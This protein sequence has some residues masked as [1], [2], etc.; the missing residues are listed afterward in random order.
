VRDWK[1]G[2]VTLRTTNDA[3]GRAVCIVTGMG[4][5][6][7]LALVKLRKAAEKE[8]Q[9]VGEQTAQAAEAH[10]TDVMRETKARQER[11][12]DDRFR[13]EVRRWEERLKRYYDEH[14][15]TRDT[16]VPHIV[17]PRPTRAV[18]PPDDEPRDAGPREYWFEVIDVRLTPTPG[19]GERSEWLAY[20][21]LAWKGSPRQATTTGSRSGSHAGDPADIG[22]QDNR[23]DRSR[24]GRD[25]R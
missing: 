18:K 12:E 20:G 7:E 5:T 2:V 24:K 21:T 22:H 3:A 8:T 23:G 11:E 6:P 1:A 10:E 9:R 25:T 14:P 13:E 15:G 19:K 17:G 16:G 4:A